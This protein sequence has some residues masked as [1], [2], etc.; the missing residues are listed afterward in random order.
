MST[1]LFS[2]LLPYAALTIRR[3]VWARGVVGVDTPASASSN[4]I[5]LDD[6]LM[7]T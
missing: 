3:Q 6:A 1:F 2:L 4:A 5:F 7:P